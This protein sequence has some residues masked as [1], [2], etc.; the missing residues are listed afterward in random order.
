MANETQAI[1]ATKQ[2]DAKLTPAEK[3]LK[4]EKAQKA[5]VRLTPSEKL[6]AR[7]RALRGDIAALNPQD[8]ASGKAYR[9]ADT[10][11]GVLT[12][13]QE[14]ELCKALQKKDI[15]TNG[16]LG[17]YDDEGNYVISEDIRKELVRV[18]K[19]SGESFEDTYYAISRSET[20]PYKTLKFSVQI[21]KVDED[22]KTA[23]LKV[24][25]EIEQLGGLYNNTVAT[26]IAE[27][28]DTDTEEF[29]TRAFELF[30]IIRLTDN[31]TNFLIEDLAPKTMRRKINLKGL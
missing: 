17:A 30:N 4:K 6:L 16:L 11:S 14:I 31:M 15:F 24:L 28:T 20:D 9:R 5:K 10:E 26:F 7:E 8:V 13:P 29:T 1:N 19:T 21:E 18:N 2:S 27:Y 3:V 23:T 12:N 22:T 25:E